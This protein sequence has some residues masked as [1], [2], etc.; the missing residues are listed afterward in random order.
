MDSINQWNYR[1]RIFCKF[2]SKEKLDLFCLQEVLPRQ[3]NDILCAMPQYAYIGR[4]RTSKKSE[5]VPI[6]Y[7]TSK[8]DVLRTETFWLSDTP[9]SVG[10]VGWDA[11]HPRIAT[12]VLL[13]IKK[14]GSIFCV[15]NTHLDHVGKEA[16]L[17]GM[18]L[19]KE[20]IKPY[21]RYPILL[22]GDM[23][24]SQESEVYQVA[25][26]EVFPMSDSFYIAKKRKGVAYSF[27]SFGKSMP[28]EKR[29][30]PDMVFVT[31]QISVKLF[32][33]PKEKM[34]KGVYMTDHCP[35]V[36]DVDIQ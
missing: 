22:L 33:I 18:K 36:V 11:K 1:K 14:T 20:R 15:V 31:S 25:L 8:Y 2:I 21:K 13:K 7:N 34:I 3:L 35:V 29:Y 9:D 19:I 26:N 10:S 6:I 32:D 28:I 4:G 27:H 23:N 30:R 17:K 24:C 12:W 16:R 5:S